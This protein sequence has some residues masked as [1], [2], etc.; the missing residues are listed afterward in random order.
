MLTRSIQP[1]ARLRLAPADFFVEP[2]E[3]VDLR[4][5]GLNNIE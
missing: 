4:K 3:K 1:I 2:A 5:I